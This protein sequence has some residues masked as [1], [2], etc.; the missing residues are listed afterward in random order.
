MSLGS[1]DDDMV[2][3]R[4]VMSGLSTTERPACS[5]LRMPWMRLASLS[6]LSG[7]ANTVLAVWLAV[8][9]RGTISIE[10]APVAAICCIA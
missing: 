3:S 5:A 6:V 7:S 1:S 9:M 10:F 4:P 2:W 8:Q